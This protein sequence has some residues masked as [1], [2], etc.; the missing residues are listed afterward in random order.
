MKRTLAAVLVALVVL[1]AARAGDETESARA[2][3]SINELLADMS[4]AVESGDVG[5][6]LSQ[7]SPHDPVFLNEQR[8]WAA[9]LREHPVA[10]FELRLVQ[11]EEL[12]LSEHG[13]AVCELAMR[14][15]TSQRR[16]WRELRFPARFEPMA[17]QEGPWFFAGEHWNIVRDE[18]HGPVNTAMALDDQLPVALQIV[19][20]MP[21]VRA[22]VDDLFG[23]TN[24]REQQIKIY[25][26]MQHLQASIYLSYTEPLGGWNEPG[27]AIKLLAG[28]GL[29]ARGLRRLLA[30]EYAHAVTFTMGDRA[31]DVDWWILEGVAEHAAEL[32]SGPTD[33]DDRLVSAWARD[34]ELRDWPQ[35]A[36]F[37][38][39][40]ASYALWVYVQ[41]Q[42][43]IGYLTDRFGDDARNEWLTMMTRG[44][45]LDEASR[46]AFGVGFARLD[47]DW[48]ESLTPAPVGPS[49]VPD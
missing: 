17:G 8:A 21:D 36:D 13:W 23:V 1:P 7:V 11:P 31:T 16:P 32:V 14:Y 49:P 9:D 33:R 34:G 6:Y 24:E 12:I 10:G 18:R 39:E 5:G 26:S 3:A 41:G 43:M 48:R 29:R 19:E 25:P 30:H 44:A 47:A 45:T 4:T 35:L 37:R 38:G 27:E 42:S 28:D 22:Q 2:R 20:L 40:A 15:K 46:A